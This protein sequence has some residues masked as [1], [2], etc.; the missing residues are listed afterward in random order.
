LPNTLKK[1]RGGAQAPNQSKLS[2]P[3]F[4]SDLNQLVK[5]DR[6]T[7]YMCCFF[8]GLTGDNPKALPLGSF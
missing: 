7:K 3:L 5:T 4:L 8:A 6:T 2:T 1:C